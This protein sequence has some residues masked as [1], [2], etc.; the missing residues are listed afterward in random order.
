LQL[1]GFGIDPPRG[2]AGSNSQLVQAMAGFG[3]S[4]ATDGVNAVSLG[5]DTSQQTLLTSPQHA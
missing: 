3:G 4:S 5:A 1:G 2:S